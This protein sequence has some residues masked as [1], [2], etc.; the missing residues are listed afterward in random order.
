MSTKR[1][2]VPAPAAAL[3]ASSDLFA[4]MLSDAGL[5]VEDVSSQDMAI[6][7]LSILQALSP[8]LNK[9]DGSYVSGA[10]QGDIYNSVTGDVY[11]EGVLVIPVA[12]QRRYT[13]WLPRTQGGGL[14]HDYGSDESVTKRATPRPTG[15]WLMPNGNELVLT[16]NHFCLLVHLGDTSGSP[17]TYERVVVAFSGTQYKKSRRWNT[18]IMATMIPGPRGLRPAPVFARAYKLDTVP[19]S[20]EKGSWYGWRITPDQFVL[21]LPDGEILYA[22]AKAF[23]E[24]VVADQYKV[25]VQPTDHVIQAAAVA[26]PDN[27]F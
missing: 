16:A 23:R 22:A 19:E 4:K 3:S 7:F 20:N 12:F 6:P 11:K 24:G 27:P 13:E 9:H 25:A 15:G 10:E 14:V 18:M 21:A 1:H 17:T 2:P 8:Q 5:G 26:D